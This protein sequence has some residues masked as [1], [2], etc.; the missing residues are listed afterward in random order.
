MNERKAEEA[1]YFLCSQEANKNDNN[2]RQFKYVKGCPP[3]GT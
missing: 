2:S 1:E 3:R